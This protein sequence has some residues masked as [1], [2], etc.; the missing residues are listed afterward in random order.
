ML[1]VAP[2][3]ISKFSQIE[4]IIA[5]RLPVDSKEIQ[6]TE[7]AGAV[8]LEFLRGIMNRFQMLADAIG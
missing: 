2:Y 8:I 5:G 7:N 3:F 4:V 6:H 1:K